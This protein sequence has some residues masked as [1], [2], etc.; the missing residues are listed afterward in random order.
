MRKFESAVS[1]CRFDALAAFFHG[2]V[3]QADH[4][5]VLHSRGTYV[6]LDFNEVRINPVHG[7]TDRFKEHSPKPV[8]KAVSLLNVARQE[9][10]HRSQCGSINYLI[11][12]RQ[13]Y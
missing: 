2:V 12:I 3:W 13:R 6:Y 1:Q 5:E 4:I 8:S 9:E 7:S 10:S 11:N